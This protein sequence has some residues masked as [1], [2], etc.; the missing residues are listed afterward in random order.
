M[1]HSACLTKSLREIMGVSLQ[2]V[3]N[4][5]ENGAILR[6]PTP[7]L[8]REATVARPVGLRSV[9]KNPLVI[10]RTK[11]TFIPHLNGEMLAPTTGS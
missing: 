11:H 2:T 1:A 4:Q 3:T 5:H 8:C 10:K 7:V 6:L 9:R